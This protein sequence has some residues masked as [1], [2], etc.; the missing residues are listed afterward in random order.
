MSRRTEEQYLHW[1]RR[2]V[3]WSGRRDPRRMGVA[4]LNKFLGHLANDLGLSPS[5][6]N[7]AS[8]AVRFMYGRV[9]GVR[10][11]RPGTAAGPIQARK[12]K[13]LP[14]VLSQEE[15]LRLLDHVPGRA[16]LICRI[17]YGSGLRLQEALHLRVKDMNLHM[18][19]IHVSGGKGARDRITMLPS[20]LAEEIR[21][22][23][24]HRSDLHQR[25]LAKGAGWAP[26][27]HP[28][29]KP[30]ES[31]Q[32]SL[33][34]Q[35]LFPATSILPDAGGEGLPGRYPLHHSAITRALG[36]ARRRSGIARH[37]TAHT[38]RHSFATHLL[39][40]GYDIRTIQELLGH[41]SVRTTMIYTHVLNRPGVGVRSPLEVRGR[42]GD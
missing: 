32:R 13:R 27:P 35:Y 29:G 15:A 5:T 31:R 42:R 41:K 11:A 19:Q 28:V 17:L 40:D 24:A 12:P 37:V 36:A 30:V 2:F 10:M 34:W 18:G 20:P 33:A 1:V 6:R 8:C 39:R 38:L 16:N 22:A 26:M 23:I 3:E 14:A 25:D 21:S 7:Q 9:L 4:E